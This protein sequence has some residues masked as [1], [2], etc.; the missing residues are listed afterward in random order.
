MYSTLYFLETFIMILGA[1]I[2]PFLIKRWGKRNITLAGSILAV[3][4]HL[5]I[6]LNPY[7]FSWFFGITLIRSIGVSQ[8]SATVF[9]MLGDVV[10]YGDWKNG[11]RQESLVFG[12][13]SLGF[14]VGTGITS[15]IMTG[16]M[17]ASGYISSTAGNAVQPESAIK[18]IENIYKYGPIIIWILAILILCVYKLDKEYPQITKA[19]NEREE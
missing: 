3:V 18:T 16:L 8:L 14:K 6:L 17:T 10:E 1:M 9:G 11:F 5:C 2:C 13:A 19:L 15:A 12:G 4:S 7:S